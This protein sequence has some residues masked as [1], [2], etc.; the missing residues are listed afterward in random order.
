[1]KKKIISNTILFLL[2]VSFI[3]GFGNMF[4]QANTL[5]GVGM[6]TIGL[7]LL[8]RDLT[9]HPFIN[10]LKLLVMN[11]I[12]GAFSHIS[13]NNMWLGIILNF[14]MLFF[15]GYILSYNLRKS[16]V[17]PFGLTYLFMLFTPV[18]GEIFLTRIIALVVGTIIIMFLQILFNRNRLSKSGI[19]AIEETYKNILIKITNI[20]EVK[21]TIDIDEK[22]EANIKAVKKIIL[23]K[24]GKDFYLTKSGYVLTDVI[25]SL[26]R[27]S[28]LLDKFREESNK[29]YFNEFLDYLYEKIQ[30]IL[31]NEIDRDK[32]KK[33]NTICLNQEYI[34]EFEE[35]IGY[36]ESDM[37]SVLEWIDPIPVHFNKI[38]NCKKD[39]NIKSLRFSLGFRI[40][41]A[42][43][44]SI[45]ITQY[46]KLEQGKWMVYTVFVLIQPYYEN[47]KIKAR[48]RIEGTI[49]GGLIVLISFSFVEGSNLRLAIIMIAGYLNPFFSNYRDMAITF[50]VSA[51]ASAALSGGTFMF[52]VTRIAFVLIGT[53]IALFVNKFI[54]P[55]KIEDG[56]K[57]LVETYNCIA[58]QMIRDIREL[59][60]GHSIKSLFLLPSLIEERMHLLKF[61]VDC[62]KESE[63]MA[64]RR[65]LINNIYKHY[66]SLK[67]NDSRK[68][69]DA[70][71]NELENS[72]N[73]K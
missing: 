52:V 37:E 29:E 65:V 17:L 28:I 69:V 66:I 57:E 49:I 7:V 60:S 6:V 51:V 58:K 5:V 25:W 72:L 40:A 59:E 43:T 34:S 39:F 35:L 4:G 47:C 64:N 36:L 41:I 56:K 30:S 15:I 2:I 53:G 1:M 20:K 10:T 50:T 21:T 9:I 13:Y 38:T 31:I 55:F 68:N 12:L 46:L 19:K 54:L 3:S 67:K 73:Y 8:E 61:G 71:I 14:S 62:K 45:F 18:E 33:V 26:E 23:D 22:I 24:R 11:I 48:Q 70:L 27:I 16:V 63:F 32:T 42:V 44:F